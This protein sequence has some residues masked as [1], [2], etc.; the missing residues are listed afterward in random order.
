M[1]A[2][3]LDR[4]SLAAMKIYNFICLQRPGNTQPK[5]TQLHHCK[6]RKTIRYSWERHDYKIQ[7]QTVSF[8]PSL[9]EERLH[10]CLL[11]SQC[12][13]VNG[14]LQL[15]NWSARAPQCTGRRNTGT[16]QQV[17]SHKAAKR[18]RGRNRSS[19]SF[20][21]WLLGGNTRVRD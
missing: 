19:L 13:T 11:H 1:N 6:F 20:Q 18:C 14:A 8:R 2:G 5:L 9:R 10:I 21:G 7:Q 12:R 17:R 3:I 15:G 4:S 16:P